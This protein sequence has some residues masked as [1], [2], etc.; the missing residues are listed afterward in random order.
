[1]LFLLLLAAATAG[2]SRLQLDLSFRPLFASGEAIAGPTREFESIFGQSSGAWIVAIIENQSADV[3][4]LLRATAALTARA[5]SIPHVVEV[6]SLTSAHIPAWSGNRLST[7]E[8][9]PAYLLEPG[10]ED[11]LKLQ[12]ESLLDGTRFVSWLV[13][14]D[15]S[16]LILGARIDLPMEDLEARRQVVTDFMTGLTDDAPSTVR[17]HFTGV[18][19][20]EL[21][22]EK[23]VLHDQIVATAITSAVLVA[24]L[25]ISFGNL[26][27]VI[28]CLTPVSLAIPATLGLMGWLGQP[29]TIIHTTIPAI[30]LVVG[31]A[32]AVHMLTAWLESRSHKMSR[33]R[34]VK[35]MAVMTGAACFFTTITTMG[36]FLSLMAAKLEMVASFGLSAA[37]GIFVAWIANQV[38]I[39]LMLRKIDA[40]SG[41][42]DSLANRCADN[43]VGN[44]L[45]FAVA[46]PVPVIVTAAVISVGC[47]FLI[48]GLRIDQKFN[49]ELPEN[50]EAS[51]AQ[52]ILERDFGGFLG[53]EL[54]IRRRDGGPVVDDASLLRLDA[55]VRAVR[56]LPETQHIW[57]VR[58]VLGGTHSAESRAAALQAMRHNPDTYYQVRELVNEDS[59][60]M[61]VIVRLGDIGTQRAGEY[62]EQLSRIASETWGPDYAVEIVGQWWLSQHGMRLLLHDM[63]IS[64]TT[65]LVVVLPML[66]LVLR[67]RRLFIAAAVANVLPLLLPLAFMAATGIVLRIGTAVVLAVAL[68]IAVDNTLHI[69]LRLRSQLDRNGDSLAQIHR[70]LHGTGRAVFFTTLAMVGGF[71]S[72][73][74][75]DLRAIHDMGIVAAVAF[76]GALIAD[77]LVL[78]AV[79]SAISGRRTGSAAELRLDGHSAKLEIRTDARCEQNE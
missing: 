17:L 77:L 79:Y 73:M 8:P 50:H 51:V 72:M 39:P 15:G 7:V 16:R 4:E 60:R 53:P 63:L 43:L 30:V 25:L 56:A 32:D 11:E 35:A 36:G 9:I 18:S 70:D 20:V 22:Y 42:S 10:D 37:V 19:V 23:Q 54:S 34:A 52:A 45:A 69:I 71:L 74:S 57:S 44:S 13:S 14:P 76:A 48:S 26:R 41:L 27:A 67:E 55:F 28:V 2:V 31:V 62:H 21:Q 29:M 33:A 49:E 38:I 3:P 47:L 78:P 75:N 46:R 58:D 68:G 66:W 61:A 6:L 12:Y 64:M 59:S 1:M 65:A 5:R 24:L 40:G